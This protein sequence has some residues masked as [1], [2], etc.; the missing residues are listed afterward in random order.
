MRRSQ[1]LRVRRRSRRQTSR[2]NV[3]RSPRRRVSNRRRTTRR[4]TSRRKNTRRSP[5]RASYRRRDIRRNVKRSRRRN[6]GGD[7]QMWEY[8]DKGNV[9]G[10]FTKEEIMAENLRD[11]LMIRQVNDTTWNK[12]V[13]VPELSPPASPV[14][15]RPVTL[16]PP[17]FAA[18]LLP[19]TKDEDLKPFQ[20][21][22]ME[23][24]AKAKKSI[25]ESISNIDE[26][27]LLMKAVNHKKEM[28]SKAKGAGVTQER[29][30]EALAIGESMQSTEMQKATGMV[31]NFLKKK[32]K[33]D[34]KEQVIDALISANVP[35]N[36]WHSELQ[37]IEAD[38]EI[39]KFFNCFQ[40]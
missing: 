23:E 12:L 7:G 27:L 29:I 21:E 15:S 22:C 37:N 38:G 14:S 40:S 36:E 17:P 18:K 19:I 39:E 24:I 25:S 10:P 1:Q 33:L 20:I 9:K 3:K 13:E 30:K 4:Q 11:T 31:G 16:H 6:T 5:R 8:M 34:L 26:H 28:I 32:N 35:S 2:R